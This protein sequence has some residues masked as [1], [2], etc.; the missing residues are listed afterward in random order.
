MRSAYLSRLLLG[1]DLHLFRASRMAS[2]KLVTIPATPW[3][4]NN[5]AVAVSFTVHTCTEQPSRRA[6]ATKARVGTVKPRYLSGTE[7]VR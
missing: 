1:L 3:S 6:A 5:R 2:T 7:S 4:H